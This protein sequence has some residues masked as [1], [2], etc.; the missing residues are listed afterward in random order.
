MWI[1]FL[2][3]IF[4]AMGNSTRSFGDK[5]IDVCVVPSLSDDDDMCIVRS[6]PNAK[7]NDTVR[8]SLRARYCKSR[9]HNV[10]QTT[11][12]R[13][14]AGQRCSLSVHSLPLMR[15][16]ICSD[17]TKSQWRTLLDGRLLSTESYSVVHSHSLLFMI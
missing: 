14:E 16:M 15:L 8:E 13:E 6:G 5:D 9:L 17:N 12:K 3:R 7:E 4:T 11:I 2:H 10:E 1:A